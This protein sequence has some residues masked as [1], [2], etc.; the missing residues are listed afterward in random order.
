MGGSQSSGW[1]LVEEG[2]QMFQGD[3]RSFILCIDTQSPDFEGISA[4]HRQN[5]GLKAEKRRLLGKEG[6]RGSQ[7]CGW[8]AHFLG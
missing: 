1:L 7:G 4:T 6:S 3:S 2:L 5:S 8:R